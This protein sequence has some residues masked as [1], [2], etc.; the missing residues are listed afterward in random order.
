M[1]MPDVIGYSLEKARVILKEAGVVEVDIKTTA[2]P[3]LRCNEF[4][5]D[6]KVIRINLLENKRIELV[7][8]KPL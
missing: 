7:V 5:D 4:N 8:C 1:Q 3:R 6:Y 2:P